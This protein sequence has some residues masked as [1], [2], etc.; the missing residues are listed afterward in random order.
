M[1]VNGEKREQ[2]ILAV[3]ALTPRRKF[4]RRIS[5]Q[6]IVTPFL[7]ELALL[8]PRWQ[9][10]TVSPQPSLTFEQRCDRSLGKANSQHSGVSLSSYFI[11]LIA[12]K[13]Y[14]I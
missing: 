11:A 3:V 9:L 5:A 14:L 8:P 13:N 2:K 12:L 7:A 1:E 4:T 6:A 10:K